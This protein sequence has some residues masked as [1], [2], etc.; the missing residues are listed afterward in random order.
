[1]G[2]DEVLEDGHALAEVAPHGHVD[3]PPDGVGH[4]AAHRAQLADVALVSTGARLGHHAQRVVVRQGRHHRVGHVPGHALP[5][6]D[7]LLVAL[8]LGDEAALEL[9][10]DLE[11]ALVRG[12]EQRALVLGYDDVPQPD[13][14]P[15][16][17]RVVEADRLDAVH[18]VGG[19]VRPE[20]AVALVDEPLELA[21]DHDPIAVAH[22]VGQDL[23]EDDPTDRR[24]AACRHERGRG[25]VPGQDLGLDRLVEGDRPE[26]IGQD[27]LGLVTEEALRL[28]RRTGRIHGQVVAAQDH[29]LGRRH[30]RRAVGR[31]EQIRGR[32]HHRPRLLTGRR[33]KRY[34][35][36]HLV[37]VEVGVERRAHERMDLDGRALDEHRH[38]CLDAQTMQRRG[39]VQQDR[40]ILDDLLE[41]VPDLG[42]DALDDALGALD[43]VGE[44]LLDELAHDERLEQL[45]R[46]L[47][48]QPALVELELRADDD[49][50]T[51][52][53]V[54]A[55]AE[56][57]L[58]EP[59]LLALEHVG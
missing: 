56:Q 44:A 15:T 49:D 25:L 43:V 3:D 9:A 41:D 11:H 7:D 46:H 42:P 1:M 31:R 54:H 55:L 37:A 57:V 13:G 45:E 47:L 59:A 18:E 4:E 2:A 36:G 20:Q 6:L 58:T 17:R 23:I 16:A 5:E 14:H 24:L 32:E 52:R 30:D 19:L 53:I 8:V 40:M 48:G 26:L 39:A 27:R 10:V 33:R 51:A 50:R 21:A 34:V 38:E 29:V 22:L 12:G 28:L 35:D